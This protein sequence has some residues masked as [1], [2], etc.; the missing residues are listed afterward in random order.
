MLLRH[1]VHSDAVNVAPR[2]SRAH[3]VHNSSVHQW[4][5]VFDSKMGVKQHRVAPGFGHALLA[6]LIAHVFEVLRISATIWEHGIEWLAI[7]AE[8]DVLGHI[9]MEHGLG[10][11]RARY[12][13]RCF[14]KV[15]RE[16]KAVR[17]E[18]AGHFDLFVPIVSSGEVVGIVVTGP[19]QIARPTSTDILERWRSL[20]GH[21]G[22][23]ADPVFASYLSATLS[24]LVLEGDDIRTFERLLGCFAGLLSGQGRAD[25][26]ANQ[27][28]VLWGRLE[29]AR[30][31]DRTWESVQELVDERSSRGAL[32][33]FND[34][35]L[36]YLGL[37]RT[38]D[39]ALVGLS[40]SSTPSRDLVDEAVRGDAFQRRAVEL[41]QQAGD[42]IAGKVGDHGVVFLSGASGRARSKTLKV[43]DLVERASS[44]ARK[45]FGLSL[46]FGASVAREA[47]PLSR[48]YQEALGA[49]EEALA[50]GSKI[51][52]AEHGVSRPNS[53]LRHLR[54]ELVRVVAE[55]PDA[56]RARFDRYLEAVAVQCAHRIDSAHA[57][58]ETGFEQMAA[59]L[60]GMGALDERSFGAL[61]DALDR[62]A[63][64]ARTL[65]DLFAAYRRAVADMADAVKRPVPARQDRGLRRAVEYI[66]QHYAEPLRLESVAGVAGI[67]PVY[68]SK[69]F[70]QREHTTF[71]DYV[72]RLRIERAKQLL[73]NTGLSVTGVAQQSGFNSPQYFC[74]VFRSATGRTPLSYRRDPV[75]RSPGRRGSKVQKKP[76][77]V[78]RSASSRPID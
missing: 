57:H 27:A 74:R 11:E 8:P 38:A 19:F 9:E 50:A 67:S 53:S 30:F 5:V 2:D 46:Y 21:Q 59:P 64:E 73:T 10:T 32:S 78:Q 18:H 15:L 37:P 13:Q 4:R 65:S 75:E 56:V 31:V 43:L 66:D 17:G 72:G 7:H 24:T 35:T 49:A 29:K 52:M 34:T 58:L 77:K 40:V 48:T 42:T 6:P 25:E 54:R 41:A 47:I 45:E 1:P 33:L 70:K 3:F 61:C 16:R 26:I 12:N 44:A 71:E 22:H 55:H 63:G 76:V 62:A 14:K 60:V 28:T 23:P 39:T 68:F 36:R 20:S 69:L 51:V